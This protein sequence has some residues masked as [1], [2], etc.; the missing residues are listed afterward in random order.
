VE[1]LL[2][3]NLVRPTVNL[4]EPLLTFTREIDSWGLAQQPTLLVA[5]LGPT[6][7][8]P[9]ADMSSSGDSEATLV[10]P[11]SLNTLVSP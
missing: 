1:P 2:V 5:D 7:A 9:I 11:L 3:A 8:V 10:L 4:W 6:T